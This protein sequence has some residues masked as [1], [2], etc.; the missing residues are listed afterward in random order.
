ME[1]EIILPA[2]I[3]TMY[4]RGSYKH[5]LIIYNSK[6]SRL[7]SDKKERA[8]LIKRGDTFYLIK[9]YTGNILNPSPEHQ[10]VFM[11]IGKMLLKENFEMNYPALKGEVSVNKK[12]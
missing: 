5:R 7:L 10:I 2:A 6:L 3:N 4:T 11:S 1:E 12:C 9:D 8:K